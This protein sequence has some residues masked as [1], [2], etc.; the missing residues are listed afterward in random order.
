[1]PLVFFGDGMFG[2]D[3]NRIK[4]HESGVVGILW[5]MLKRR[6]ARGEIALVTISE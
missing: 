4:G 1:M 2:K 5:K 6:E 3:C